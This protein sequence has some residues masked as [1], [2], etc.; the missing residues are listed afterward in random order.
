VALDFQLTQAHSSSFARS[1]LNELG[2]WFG[3][4]GL[5]PKLEL[6]TS[7]KLHAAAQRAYVALSRV[8]VI[9]G[10]SFRKLKARKPF[11]T[12]AA[13]RRVAMETMIDTRFQA[14]GMQALVT[15]NA[16]Q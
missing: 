3:S 10:Y 9:H 2:C 7:S 4:Y 15:A 14:L 12:D 11:I 16:S 1:I 6:L 5:Q 13:A 8:S